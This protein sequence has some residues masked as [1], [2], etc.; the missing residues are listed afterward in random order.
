MRSDDGDKKNPNATSGIRLAVISAITAFLAAILGACLAKFFDLS[1]HEVEELAA[2]G[3]LVYGTGLFVRWVVH[4]RLH[5]L[6]F[7]GQADAEW[8]AWKRRKLRVLTIFAGAL[9]AVVIAAGCHFLA[10]PGH[11]FQLVAT[12]VL[13]IAVWL[14]VEATRETIEVGG[15]P[16]GA[17]VIEQCEPIR[18]L[19]DPKKIWNGKWGLDTFWDLVTVKM[20]VGHRSKLAVFLIVGLLSAATTQA[21]AMVA[22][23]ISEHQHQSSEKSAHHELAPAQPEAEVPAPRVPEAS[24]PHTYADTC[25]T[26]VTPGDGLPE[27]L[28]A[29]MKRA[30]E[31]VSPAAGC[32]Q[33]ARSDRS[34]R[35][36]L[37]RGECR[38]RSSSLGIASWE[39]GAAILL[40]NASIGAEQVAGET[41]IVGAS[42][43]ADIANGDFQ[44]IYTPEGP[45]LLIRAQKTDGHGGVDRAPTDCADIKPG[46]ETYEVLTPGMAELYLRFNRGVEKAWPTSVDRQSGGGFDL[47]SATGGGVVAH[48]V[49]PS[50]TE[51][52]LA[53]GEIELAATAA[54]IDEVTV[55]ALQIYG[56]R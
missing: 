11:L 1:I 14:E 25:G 35:A 39:Y 29:E 22:R 41:E 31:E 2:L 51:C 19:L 50:R 43:R 8:E 5:Y 7:R 27:P 44:L 38:G 6:W 34:G 33:R 15:P 32:A 49:C 3:L 42:A 23:R 4:V 13:L 48:A 47:V 24:G 17:D 10:Q 26:E 40:E 45:Y 53:G 21:G 36:F 46:K 54:D 37:I 16:C 28:R 55:P 9:A 56:P 12:V 52:L 18:K 20:P 30:W